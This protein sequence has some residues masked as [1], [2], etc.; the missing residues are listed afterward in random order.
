[1]GN[2]FSAN[3]HASSSSSNIPLVPFSE[4]RGPRAA[5]EPAKHGNQHL[6]RARSFSQPLQGSVALSATSKISCVVPAETLADQLREGPHTELVEFVKSQ[7]IVQ[8]FQQ[9][10]ISRLQDQLREERS[11]NHGLQTRAAYWEDKT[12]EVRQK[13][14]EHKQEE[15]AR[16]KAARTKTKSGRF[17]TVDGGIRTAVKRSA[18]GTAGAGK[19]ADILDGTSR[20]SVTFWELK[21]GICLLAEARTWYRACLVRLRVVW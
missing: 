21:V 1:M 14:K 4:P 6:V 15:A 20:Q 17:F 19:I 9:N 8:T 11:K 3:M 7:Q 12:K 16:E 10:E 18:A 5:A 2:E 13:F